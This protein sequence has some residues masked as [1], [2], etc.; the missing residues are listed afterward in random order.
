MFVFCGRRPRGTGFLKFKTAD[1]ADAATSAAAQV[2]SG[3]GILLKGRQLKVLKAM[4]KTSA[5]KK[6]MEKLKPDVQDQRNLYLAKVGLVKS[7]QDT[8]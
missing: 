1:A 3:L 7:A 6:E 2:E 5:Q 8:P 4:D